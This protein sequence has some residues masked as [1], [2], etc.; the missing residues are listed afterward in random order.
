MIP[1]LTLEF[2]ICSGGVVTVPGFNIAA[3]TD[4]KS[5]DIDVILGSYIE[6]EILVSV[7]DDVNAENAFVTVGF[8]LNKGGFL[9]PNKVM[10]E[11]ST[12]DK[13]SLNTAGIA[14]LG[15]LVYG[16]AVN[17]PHAAFLA[18]EVAPVSV[19]SVSDI[20]FKVKKLEIILGVIGICRG[21]QIYAEN[22]DGNCYGK[23]YR[24][25]FFHINIL[26]EVYVISR[27]I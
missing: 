25:D 17:I 24:N 20:V 18:G 22:S 3:E 12:G 7:S 23:H 9:V 14:A 15:E 11:G 16:L 8:C 4:H 6:L 19:G 13:G 1:G 5:S 27:V 21:R 10:E 26:L 2:N